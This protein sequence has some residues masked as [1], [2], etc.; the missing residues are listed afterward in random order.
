MIFIQLF[1]MFHI[2]PRR[3]FKAL[4]QRI[5]GCV[6]IAPSDPLGRYSIGGVRLTQSLM[7]ILSFGYTF[8]MEETQTC[9][10]H[11]L[12]HRR[13]GRRLVV[14]PPSISRSNCSPVCNPNGDKHNPHSPKSM[15]REWAGLGWS[16]SW[17]Q[18]NIP[19]TMWC[20]RTTKGD[21]LGHW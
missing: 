18:L 9:C 3:R 1:A 17:A 14:W 19:P 11:S 20:E 15:E 6:N 5:K 8:F 16:P 12:W 10:R 21:N 4:C 13:H 2:Q 7:V